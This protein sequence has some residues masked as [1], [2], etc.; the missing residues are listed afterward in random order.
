MQVEQR[1]HPAGLRRLVAPRRQ[2]RRREPLAL[3][4]GLIDALIVHPWRLYLDRA[5]R[6]G[7]LPSLVTA[8]ADHQAAPLVVALIGELG[9][10]RVDF[11]LQRDGQ[12]PPCA[13]PDNLIQQRTAAWRGAVLVDYRKHGRA[14]PTDAATSAL[15]DDLSIDPSGRYAPFR[16]E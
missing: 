6:G 10:V 1:Q 5:G 12:H 13:F 11:G 3:A 8:V 7:D 9:H 4:R 15:L 2:D 14:F 16:Q